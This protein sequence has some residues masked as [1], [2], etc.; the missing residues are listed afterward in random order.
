MVG[1]CL[2]LPNLGFL[3]VF[4]KYSKIS[5]NGNLLF[6][7]VRTYKNR[8]N[9]KNLTTNEL[10]EKLKASI[11]KGIDRHIPHKFSKPKDN[12]PWITPKIK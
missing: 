5:R 7:P 11:S 12:L 10:W 2:T 3:W 9:R 8:K 6:L 1:T 4:F